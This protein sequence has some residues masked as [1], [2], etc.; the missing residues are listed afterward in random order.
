MNKMDLTWWMLAKSVAFSILAF[1]IF[2]AVPQASAT[3]H[4]APAASRTEIIFV[5]SNVADYQGLLNSGTKPGAEVHLLDASQNGLAQMAQYLR[6]RSGVNAIHLISHGSEGSLQLGALDLNA[7]NLSGHAADLTVIGKALSRGGEI[8][9]YGC[10][11]AA[12]GAGQQFVNDFAAATGAVVAASSN[13]T[14][15]FALGGDWVLESRTG[16]LGAP[17]LVA[18]G[19]TG[20]LANGTM[21]FSSDGGWGGGIATDGQGGS[22]DLA[23]IAIQVLNISDTN[24]T[25]LGVAIQWKNNADLGSPAGGFTGLTTFVYA[26]GATPWKG[27]AI[28]SSDGSEFQINQF[29]WHD[30][31]WVGG[32]VNVVGYLNGSQVTS[33]SFMANSDASVIT[34]SLGTGFDF[35]DEVRITYAS[36]GYPT[37]NDIVIADAVAPTP[38]ITS[39]TYNA[40]TNVLAVTGTNMTAGGTID[41]SKL[42]LTGE[43]GGTYTL[44]SANV[45]AASSTAFSVTLNGTDEVGIESLLNKNGTSS[46]SITTYSLAAATNWDVTASAAADLTS[47]G[48]TVSSVAFPGAP[49]IGTATAG[50]GQATVTFTPGSTGSS[51]TTSYTATSNPGGL[52]SSGCTSSPCTVTGLSNG[53][54]YTFTVTGAN[55]AG[56][57]SASSASN[58]V[59]PKANQTITFGNP[60]V[61]NFGT[62]PTLSATATSG[63][64]VSF[65]SSTTGVCTIT[66]GGTLT[67]VTVGTCTIDADQSGNGTYLAA[68]TVSRSFT[69]NA[70]VPGAPTIGTATA[71]DTQASVTF[72]APGANGGAAI[73]GYTATANPGGATGTGPSSPIAVT[74]LING[75]AYTFTVTATNSAGTGSA[76]SASN[77]VTPKAAQTI[78]F[79]N[80]GAQNFGTTPTLS[81]TSDSGLIPTFTSSTTGVCTITTG[82]ALTFVTTGTCTIDADQPG[83]GSYLAATTVA[84]S[85]SVNAVAPGAPT[86]GTA[87]AGNAQAA[88]TFSAPSSNGGSA[89]T[90]YAVTSSPGGLTGSA[91][92]SPVTV[93]G[94][95]NGTAYTFTVTATSTAGTGNASSASNSVTP[96]TVPGAPIIGAPTGGNGQ[97][98]VAFTAP[99]NGGS[100]ITGYTATSSPGGLASSGCTA[101]PCTVAGLANGTAYSFTVTATNA[102]GTGSASA[103]SSSVTPATVP[104]APTIGTATAGNAQASVA[105][106]APGSNGGVIITGYTATSNPGGL[107]GTGSSPITV[108]G[109]T[110]GTAYTFTVTATNAAGTGS[111]SSASNSVT[112]ATV[113]G[114]PTIGTATA[115]DAQASVTFLAPGST[116]GAAI[117]SYTV[118]S[119]PGGLTDSAASSP[120]TVTGLTNGVAYTFTV[121][122]TNSSGTG[123]ASSATNSVTP[124]ANQTITFTNPGTKSFGTT[125]T[126]TAS[127]S[128]SLAVSFSSSTTGVC[129][130]TS[131]GLLGFVSA[132]MCTID[133]DQAGNGSYLPASQVSQS[134]S[135]TAIVPGIPTGA[136]AT[137]DNGQATVSFSAP[138]YTGGANVTSYTVTA[139]PGGMTVSGASS[140]LTVTGLTNGTAYTFTVVATNLAG[141]SGAS[142]ASNSV[143]P[144]NGL[145]VIAPADITVDAVGL[146]TPVAIGTA[147]VVGGGITPTVTL[148]N[149][150]SVTT[151]PANFRPGVNSVTWSATDGNSATSTATQH[152]NVRP[153]VDFNKSQVSAEGSTVRIKVILNGSAVAYPVTIPYTVSGTAAIDGSDH[154]LVNGNVVIASGLEASVNVQ[155]VNDGVGEGTETLVITMGTPDNAVAGKVTTHTVEIREDNVAPT[156]VLSAVQGSSGATRLIGQGGG[157]V[158][159]TAAM[160]DP[161]VGDVHTYNWSSS[162]NA[163]VDTDGVA[164]TFSIDPV[165][166]TP[167]IYTFKVTVS[168]GTASGKAELLVKVEAAL[169]T[170]TA[171]D[172]DADGINDDVEGTGDSDGDGIP[173]YLDSSILARNVL[174]EKR[175]VATQYLME[176]EPGLALSLGQTAL[177][178]GGHNTSVSDTDVQSF[179]NNGAGAVA[180][181]GFAYSGGLFD[182]NVSDLPAAGQPIKVVIPQF[183]VVP[184]NAIYRKLMSTGWQAF[185]V[186]ANNSVA[187]ALGSE[188]YC[189]PPGDSSYTAGLTEGHWC[190]Q[191]TVE[192]GGPNDA[193]GV[194]NQ[195]VKDPGG[196]AQQTSQMLTITITGSGGGG[197]ATSYWSLLLL[198]LGLLMRRSR[199]LLVLP[200]MLVDTAAQAEGSLM[201]SYVGLSYMK[202]SSSERSSDFEGDL[203]ALGLTGTVTQTDLRRRGWSPYIGYQMEKWLAIELGYVDLGKV[204]TT[205]AGTTNDVNTY[206][207]TA[208]A[209][210][211]TTASGWTF[212]FVMRKA[213]HER[214]DLLARFGALAWRADYTL[215]SATASRSFRDDGMDITLGLGLE[216]H[217]SPHL[218]VRLGWSQYRFAGTNVNALELGVGYRF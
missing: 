67:F 77:S 85:F 153:L 4:D 216:M 76:S 90:A 184:A 68:S 115:G 62:T 194:A 1:L 26:G 102:V 159:V 187:S 127:A 50:V 31:G 118:T 211:P 48:V 100:A 43:G 36:S 202:V 137:A 3:T 148:V 114:A 132:G 54:A 177:Q 112:P 174:Q 39:A 191:L 46:V 201:P 38:T 11:V 34:V 30:W 108:S 121:T 150:Q 145:T 162:D 14:G 192:D 55:A 81:A 168:D 99:S 61:Q 146:F 94:L 138:I 107:T 82:G 103:S 131:G 172:S 122:A 45:T 164:N 163:L 160:T 73:T 25:N 80:P 44:T 98:T 23:G 165:G 64:S 79:G 60:G 217:A 116:G 156:V 29:K 212:N 19:Y 178:A 87:T 214:V 20:L 92:S 136:S 37:I 9:L 101:S 17:T 109:L 213:V 215:V 133:V 143:T 199:L 176:T 218:P 96:M 59:T 65:S 124:K 186:N 58:S 189:P 125:P 205:I 161:N 182:F 35:V 147:T 18:L 130:I 32:T 188:G 154:N 8:L 86:I 190:V 84:R 97:A 173:D 169:P 66:S 83:N 166:L 111:A 158:V 21:S 123:I 180:D 167:G 204:T 51:A 105:F 175:L 57:G 93:T 195:T 206:L 128:S 203:A 49:T 91:V 149:G 42:T 27:M 56:T 12:G 13:D 193:D 141:N 126:L 155:L 185:V 117:S 183:A 28:K 2:L 157:V 208:S 110:N 120:I 135:V 139:T 200:L 22:T 151:A 181:D 171:V 197:G 63:L 142:A 104:D 71:G 53:T 74:G 75:V 89:I 196:V 41:V 113:P 198:G 152:V 6:D 7:Q 210:H 40:S 106:S 15:A 119:S 88:V 69:V 179:A 140:P 144:S 16:V 129:T 207:D 134:F 5:E 10:S 95:T 209:V 33:T 52:T 72:S 78:T 170:L 47:N 24:G 70:V